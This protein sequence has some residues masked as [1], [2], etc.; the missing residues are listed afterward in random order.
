M[1]AAGLAEA[2]RRMRDRHIDERSVRV[3]ADYYRQLEQGAQGTIPEASIEP[4]HDVPALGTVTASEAARVDAL[5]HTAIVKLNGGLG[6]SMGLHGPKS[7]LA[8]RGALT[9][10]DVIARQVRALRQRYA[11]SLPVLFMDSFRTR[12]ETLEV[13]AGYPDLPVEGLPLD[14]LQGAEPKLRAEDLTPV[15]WPADPELEWCPPG[16]GDV[17][18]SLL[19]SGLLD[20]LRERGIRRVF[21]SNADNLGATCDPDIAA[22]MSE[23]EVPYLAEVCRRTVNDRKGGHLARRRRDGHIVLRDSAMVVPGEEGH[24]ADITRHTT[25]HANNLWVDLD[26]VARLLQERGGI[27]G[28]PIIVNRKS[29]DPTD[30]DSTKV[31]QVESAMGAAI[32][33]VEGSQA[34]LVPRSRFRP[35]KTTNELALIRSDRYELDEASQVVSTTDRPEPLVDLDGH[36]TLVPDFEARFPHG[37]PSLRRCTS[38][39]VR[40]EVTFGAGVVCVGDVRVEAA[41]PAVVPDGTRLGNGGGDGP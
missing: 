2:V 6:T 3:F 7:A 29:V 40:G 33:A 14:F 23:H 38:L 10:L 28:L 17:Y 24:F 4:L 5:R 27:L 34:L 13:L 41:T 11:V 26:V 25:F 1:S 39:L 16:H 36:Y 8:V 35:V 30:K 19:T 21:L 12:Q 37:V 15:D 20:S 31:I 22:W 18:L 32:E 9:F